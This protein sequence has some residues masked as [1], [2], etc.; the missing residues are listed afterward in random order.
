MCFKSVLNLVKDRT[1]R[2]KFGYKNFSLKFSQKPK[3][4]NF[5]V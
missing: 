5:S 2:Q 4:L 3:L 1:L